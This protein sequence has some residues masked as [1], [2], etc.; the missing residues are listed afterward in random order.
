[1]S[2]A[3]IGLAAGARSGADSVRQNRTFAPPPTSTEERATSGGVPF[4]GMG[5]A[6]STGEK[7]KEHKRKY[8][9]VEQHDEVIMV[10]PPVIGGER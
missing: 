4:G 8:S 5:G 6:R 3:G 7:D 10:A 9:V 1:M 2:A